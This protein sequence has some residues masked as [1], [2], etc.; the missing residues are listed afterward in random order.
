MG[1]KKPLR[2]AMWIHST[3][4]DSDSTTTVPTQLDDVWHTWLSDD[5]SSLDFSQYW[6]RTVKYP[7]CRYYNIRDSWRFYFDEEADITAWILGANLNVIK[8]YVADP[9]IAP[10]NWGF[11]N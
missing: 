6:N 3:T 7:E 11:F 1:I 8:Q 5:Y 2:P 4:M 10:S 9:S